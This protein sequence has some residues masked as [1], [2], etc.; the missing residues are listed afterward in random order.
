MKRK[1]SQIFKLV[2]IL[3][4]LGAGAA[5]AKTIYVDNRLSN[6]CSGNYSIAN[7]SCTGSDGDAY[8]KIQSA[9]D[10]MNIG[11][12][13][14]IRG[15]I[16]RENN[17]SSSVDIMISPSK[18]GDSWEPGHF[19]TLAS[20]PGEWAVIDG[21]GNAPKG[22]VLGYK[23][24]SG[25]SEELHYWKF[26][27]LEITGGCSPGNDSQGGAGLWIAGGPV[28][29]RYCYI[30]DNWDT[31][32]LNNPSGLTTYR[33]QDSIIEYNYFYHNGGNSGNN[34]AHVANYSDYRYNDW[35]SVDINHAL[36][37]NEWR[38]NYFEDG[39]Y[40]IKNKAIQLLSENGGNG[41]M[42]YKG[43]GDKI[44]HNI[45]VNFNKAAILSNQD[46]QQVY[47]NIFNSASI[48]NGEFNSS[49][50]FHCC[51]YNNTLIESHFVDWGQRSDGSFGGFFPSDHIFNNIWVDAPTGTNETRPVNIGAYSGTPVNVSNLEIEHNYWYNPASPGSI[52]YLAAQLGGSN[53]KCGIFSVPGFDAEYDVTN[54]VKSSSEGVDNLFEG[55]SG[56]NQYITRPSHSTGSTTIAT[57]GRGGGHPYLAGVTIPSYLG[58]TNPVDR[59]WVSGVLNDVTSTNWLRTQS[60]GDPSWIEGGGGSVS[61]PAQVQDFK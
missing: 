9:L 51:Y 47:N 53:S 28:I 52:F 37:K 60:D 10:A 27:R 25:Y 44:H 35:S 55:S 15:G 5:F 33:L 12:T 18:N 58:A 41:D 40:G 34:C 24:M 56:A 17:G 1:I 23:G 19:N 43:Y 14:L 48:D 26:E 29:I 39:H 8:I 21:E 61:R 49:F 2:L 57:G 45:F 16:Y 3:V 54:Y 7:R 59:A 30:H 50:R 4:F 22:V 31:S 11:D 13:I 42:L 38:Y 20:Y 6:N 46:F 32:E 36:R